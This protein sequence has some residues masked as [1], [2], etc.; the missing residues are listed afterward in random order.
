M[1]AVIDAPV[2][3]VW[4]VLRDFNAIP[5]WFE[6]IVKSE[7][8][9]GKA[10]DQTG[11]IRRMTL[12]DGMVAHEQL[13]G[14]SEP[15]YSVTYGVL[16]KS[17]VASNVTGRFRLR[18]ITETGQTF[19]EWGHEFEPEPGHADAAREIFQ[20]LYPITFRGVRKACVALRG[21][22]GESGR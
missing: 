9:N 10:G 18:P 14:M 12:A 4:S 16:S 2:E 5:N 8:E 13:T 20:S 19:I 15:D 6:P 22:G 7:I 17:P 21:T 3:I 11:V 1:S